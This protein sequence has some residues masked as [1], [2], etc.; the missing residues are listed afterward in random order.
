[1]G[2]KFGFDDMSAAW[3]APRAGIRAAM[4]VVAVLVV[5]AR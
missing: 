5:L 4:A 1:M 3:A 2:V